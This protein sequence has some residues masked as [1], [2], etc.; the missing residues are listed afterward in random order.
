[1]QN[2]FAVRILF[3]FLLLANMNCNHPIPAVMEREETSHWGIGKQVLMFVVMQW[4]STGRSL[5]LHVLLPFLS[6]WHTLEQSWAPSLWDCEILPVASPWW[7]LWSCQRALR[8][9]S[10][11]FC[12]AECPHGRQEDEQVRQRLQLHYCSF[13]LPGLT[14]TIQLWKLSPWQHSR[15]WGTVWNAPSASFCSLWS[16]VC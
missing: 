14:L 6:L 15:D 11:C 16:R 4:V 10:G 8:A 3:L 1:M 12:P 13:Q 7:Q 5:H 2:N 9:P